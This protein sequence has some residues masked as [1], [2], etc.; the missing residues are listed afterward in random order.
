MPGTYVFKLFRKSETNWRHITQ[1]NELKGTVRFKKCLNT[2]I[3]S[4]LDIWGQCYKTF[5]GRKLR[6]FKIS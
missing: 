1:H 2:N 3:Y 4:Y 5:Y 6:L